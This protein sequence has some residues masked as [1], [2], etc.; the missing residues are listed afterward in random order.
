[1]TEREKV[2]LSK[3][4]VH[5]SS[6]DT[7]IHNKYNCKIE[8]NFFLFFLFIAFCLCLFNSYAR[9]GFVSFYTSISMSCSLFFVLAWAPRIIACNIRP[10]N[11]ISNKH[12]SSTL[13]LNVHYSDV[14]LL[15]SRSLTVLGEC[16]IEHICTA[17]ANMEWLWFCCFFFFLCHFYWLTHT[18]FIRQFFSHSNVIRKKKVRLLFSPDSDCYYKINIF[19]SSSGDDFSAG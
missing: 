19:F 14:C 9:F 1:M 2:I 18:H 10:N 8:F 3:Y 4:N 17:D 6:T 5:T 15:V 16:A 13:L 11:N 7:L 12:F